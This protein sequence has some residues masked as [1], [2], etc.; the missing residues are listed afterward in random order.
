MQYQY[1][2]NQR[3]RE[4]L[5]S[6]RRRKIKIQLTHRSLDPGAFH[7]HHSSTS[8]SN[9]LQMPSA[10][11]CSSFSCHSAPGICRVDRRRNGG[12]YCLRDDPSIW[13]SWD[14][15]CKAATHELLRQGEISLDPSIG[16]LPLTGL[17]TRDTKRE[18]TGGGTPRCSRPVRHHHHPPR[19]PQNSTS[20]KAVNVSDRPGRTI[21][22][23][24][25]C[26]AMWW[27]TNEKNSA[28]F[29]RYSGTIAYLESERYAM[30]IWLAM[31][32]ITLL[33]ALCELFFVAL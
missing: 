5:C 24:P 33:A 3:E 23:S 28:L 20:H 29:R 26:F 1:S 4:Q 7:H 9:Y 18:P 16:S 8:K 14:D 6:K 25:P 31:A 10:D 22:T 30:H 32:L 11:I 21:S 27:A 19:S 2:I 12:L 17:P 15:I 13:S